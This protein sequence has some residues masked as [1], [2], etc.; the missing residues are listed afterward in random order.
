MWQAVSDM[1]TEAEVGVH[2]AGE[3]IVS[4]SYFT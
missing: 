1:G 2:K 3:E 4:S